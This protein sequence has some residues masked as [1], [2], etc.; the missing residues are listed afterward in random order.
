MA[1][2]TVYTNGAEACKRVLHLLD[3]RGLPY[4]SLP[5]DSEADRAMLVER[6]GRMTCPAVFVGEHLLGGLQETIAAEQSG[7]LAELINA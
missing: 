4:T 1:E 7:R 2:I 5:V 3:A 6:T